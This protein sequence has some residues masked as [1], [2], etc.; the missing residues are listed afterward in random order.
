[1]NCQV[2]KAHKSNYPNPIQFKAGDILTIGAEDKEYPGWIWVETRDRNKG[3]AP[4]KYIEIIGSANRGI[5]KT[6]YCARELKVDVGE[7]LKIIKSICGWHYVINTIG[8]EGWVPK[9]CIHFA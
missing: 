3:W 2:I 9:E 4:M 5:A 6:S 7:K 1:M 8:E